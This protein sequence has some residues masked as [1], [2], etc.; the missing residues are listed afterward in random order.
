L[1]TAMYRR[2]LTNS[3]TAEVRSEAIGNLRDAGLTL[4]ASPVRRIVASAGYIASDAGGRSGIM[5]TSTIEFQSRFVSMGAQ[6]QR[7]SRVFLQLGF[8]RDH[9]PARQV[10]AVFFGGSA[11]GRDHLS[12]AIFRQ[13]GPLPLRYA[14]GSYSLNVGNRTFW[15]LTYTAN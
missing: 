3:L 5:T 14:S 6:G 12:A 11:F 7:A 4:T 13:D 1:G 8:D 15:Q 9:R 10:A 2:G